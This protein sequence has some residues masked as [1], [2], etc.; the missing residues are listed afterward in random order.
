MEVPVASPILYKMTIAS[1][2]ITYAPLPSFL[3][4]RMRYQRFKSVAIGFFAKFTSEYTSPS[5]FLTPELCTAAI[6]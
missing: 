2:S 1:P 4:G 5:I 6:Y 3:V